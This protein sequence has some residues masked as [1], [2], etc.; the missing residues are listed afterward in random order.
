[1]KLSILL[2][3][4]AFGAF[5]FAS[6][7]LRAQS[8]PVESNDS[9]RVSVTLNEDGSRTTYQFDNPNHKAIATTTGRDG[10][11]REKIEY[12][13]DEAGRFGSGRIFGSDGK[14]QYRSVYKYDAAGHL[15][16]ESKFGKDDRLLSKIVYAYDSA[17]KQ[18]GYSVY[19]GAGKLIGQ[20]SSPGPVPP[21][22]PRKGGR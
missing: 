20:T 6:F 13:L 19:D 2:R 16:E 22:K 1:M 14:F 5:T 3:P 17:G 4:L 15:Q 7:S 11:P 18:S 12:Q 9:I 8:A 10:K 21:A